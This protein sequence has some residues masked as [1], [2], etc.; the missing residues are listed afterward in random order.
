MQGAFQDGT[1]QVGISEGAMEDLGIPMPGS[2]PRLPTPDAERQ[3]MAAFE[4]HENPED[5]PY[6]DPYFKTDEEKKDLDT[7]VTL[8]YKTP[9][10]RASQRRADNRRSKFR[11]PVS[12]LPWSL[13]DELQAEKD[14]F[15]QEKALGKLSKMKEQ[16]EKEERKKMKALEAEMDSD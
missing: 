10:E 12:R 11:P 16:R 2:T 8:N 4:T 13:L 9:E 7:D 14:S 5:D 15:A 6:E 1:D 3:G